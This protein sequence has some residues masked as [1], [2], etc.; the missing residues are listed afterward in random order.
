M[1]LRL[2]YLTLTLFLLLYLPH[3]NGIHCILIVG[4]EVEVGA[5]LLRAINDGLVTREELWITSKLWNTFHSPEHVELAARK[6]LADLG[7]DYFD[8]CMISHAT[9]RSK[10]LTSYLLLY[11]DV[12]H[13]PISLK[14]VPIDVRYPPEWIHDP[15]AEKPTMIANPVPYSATWKVHSYRTLRTLYLNR[16]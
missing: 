13:F 9:I 5:G 14:Y 11:T 2:R 16:Y 7:L 10:R 6:S 4:N 8:L 15:S 3:V 1:C 12:I